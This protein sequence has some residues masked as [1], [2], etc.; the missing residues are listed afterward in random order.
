[1]ITTKC[2]SCGQ[3][4]K[5]PE[6]LVGKRVKCPGCGDPFTVA[7]AGAPAPPAAKKPAPAAVKPAPRPAPRPAPPPLVEDD[8]DVVDEAPRKRVAAPPD[9]DE[10]RPTGTGRGIQYMRE[11]RYVFANPKWLTN[12][13]MAALC[14]LIPVIGGLVTGGYMFEVLETLHREGDDGYPDFDFGRFSKYLMRGLWP[15][16]VVLVLLAPAM[17]LLWLLNTVVSIVAL[18]VLKDNAWILTLPVNL[19]ALVVFVA[20]WLAS[21][22]AIMRAGLSQ[23]MALGATISFAR[24]FVSRVGLLLILNQLFLGVTGMVVGFIGMLMCCVGAF[25]AAALI[26]M[27]HIHGMYQLYE[28]YLDRGGEPVPLK[29]EE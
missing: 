21:V 24:D 13:I 3:A 25:P 6:N 18:L 11:Y 23:Q 19:L 29:S 26:G 22:P 15:F 8:L 4:A 14:N 27:A 7:A 12:L 17:F 2:P 9:D 20:V 10:S 1:M 16:L 5:V 28:V